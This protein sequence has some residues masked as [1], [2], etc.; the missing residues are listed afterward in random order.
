MVIES[1]CD[2]N[3]T[4]HQFAKHF[5]FLL[6]EFNKRFEEFSELETFLMFFINP[7]SH[8]N[9]DLSEKISTD[10]S[11]SNKEDLELEIIN[12]TNDIQ[13]K[14]YC[15]E[16]NFWNLVDINIYPLLRKCALKLNSL[17][18]STY[19]CESLFSNM[20]YLKSRYRSTLT[21]AHLDQCLPT[22]NSTYIFHITTSWPQIYSAKYL[23][24]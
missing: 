17:C 22:G 18:A 16:E 23:T 12:I 6:T 10:F 9:E 21:D 24:R 13:V 4:I 19:A 3:V 15:N 1:H 8:R 5:D 7:Y 2:E 11:I 20:K 14:S